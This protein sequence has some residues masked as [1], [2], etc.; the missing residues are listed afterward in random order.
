MP[1]LLTPIDLSIEP[2]RF[3]TEPA[4]YN[5]ETQT[6]GSGSRPWPTYQGTRTYDAGGRPVDHDN[7]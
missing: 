3:Q 2:I 5:Y 4:E 6:R 7:D 1:K